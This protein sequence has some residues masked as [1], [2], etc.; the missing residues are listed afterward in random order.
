VIRFD[1]RGFTLVELMAIV[2]IMGVLLVVTVG[3]L[4]GVTARGR[5]DGAVEAVRGHIAYARSEALA[6]SSQYAVVYEIGTG[7]IRFVEPDETGR[8][9]NIDTF[10][11]EHT[12]QEWLLP[13]GVFV[14]EGALADE[15]YSHGL[16]T[17]FAGPLGTITYHVVRLSD[18]DG[19]RV[20]LEVSALTG[21]VRR[22]EDDGA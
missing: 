21:F 13:H 8:V 15:T 12:S 10:I 17:V 4:A 5:M 18:A 3:N 7:V 19:R 20:N 2:V 11:A 1:R 14:A 22:I 6:T 9:L 16:M